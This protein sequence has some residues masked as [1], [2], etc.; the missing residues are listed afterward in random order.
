MDYE[1]LERVF[2]QNVYP[3]SPSPATFNS[4]YDSYSRAVALKYGIKA[5]L[6][7]N[8]IDVSIKSHERS[9]EKWRDKYF[10]GGYWWTKD[11]VVKFVDYFEGLI[12]EKTVRRTIKVFEEEGVLVSHKM[13]LAKLSH[14]KWYRINPEA[15]M[16]IFQGQSLNRSKCPNHDS[17]TMTTSR[18]GHQFRA[19]SV[20]MTTSPYTINQTS[21]L[22][23]NPDTALSALPPPS[24]LGDID[25]LDSTS[26][27]Q[28][29]ANSQ[30][31]PEKQSPPH[32]TSISTPK[33]A[34]ASRKADFGADDLALAK[35]WLDFAVR[36][37]PHMERT[38]S[39]TIEGF[40]QE[41]YRARCAVEVGEDCVDH[42]GMRKIF[43]F[44]KSD[45][46]FWRKNAVSPCGLLKRKSGSDFRKIDHIINSMKSKSDMK[47]EKTMDAIAAPQRIVMPF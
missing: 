46:G 4:I 47:N 42:V 22:T 41:I 27:N 11:P 24:A 3:E 39:W 14:T 26:S 37:M 20:T 44:I 34:K 17:V 29:F 10:R 8:R 21:N 1:T 32:K 33:K 16:A 7:L 28:T 45:V 40:A 12:S 19:D 25:I 31:T 43:D 9:A 36:S 18:T 35:D 38:A 30:N 6:I 2:M 23:I 5:A 13:D 15:I